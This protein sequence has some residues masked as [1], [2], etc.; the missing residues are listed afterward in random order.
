MVSLTVKG[1]RAQSLGSVERHAGER[2]EV[3]GIGDGRAL[4][5]VPSG[6]ESLAQKEL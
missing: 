1:K 6:S 5:A 2:L 3:A 4:G